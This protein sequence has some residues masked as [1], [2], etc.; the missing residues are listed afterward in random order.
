MKRIHDDPIGWT[1]R[2]SK[3]TF[4]DAVDAIS[5]MMVVVRHKKIPMVELR[6]AAAIAVV[7][8]MLMPEATYNKTDGTLTV[9]DNK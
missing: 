6:K 7:H 2:E 4:P 1:M 5:A 9:W 3:M 8:K